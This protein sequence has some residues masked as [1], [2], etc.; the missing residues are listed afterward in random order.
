MAITVTN[1]ENIVMGN[2]RIVFATIALDNSYA[3]GG[4][5][6]TASLFGLGAVSWAA[7]IHQGAEWVKSSNKLLFRNY[8]GTE[9]GSGVD[10]SGITALPVIILGS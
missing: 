2:K 9:I 6:L 1:V 4:Y 8:Q 3:T 10:L 5:A 7:P